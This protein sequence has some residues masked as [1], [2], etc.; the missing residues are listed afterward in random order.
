[1]EVHDLL[2]ILRQTAAGTSRKEIASR[3]G[4]AKSTVQR[5]LNRLKTAGITPEQAMEMSYSKLEDL[6]GCGKSVRNGFCLPDFEHAYCRHNIRGK[7][8]MSLKEL[9]QSY[10]VQ[11]PQ[12]AKTLGYKGYVRAYQRFCADLPASCRDIELINEWMFGDVAMI[13]YSGDT[14]TL[15]KTGAKQNTTAQIFVGVLPASGYI[16]CFAT[17]RQTRDDWLDAQVKMLEYF[18]GV[19]KHIYLDNTKALVIKADKYAPKICEEYLGF[20]DYYGTIAVAVRPGKPRDKA[21]AENAVRLVQTKILSELRGREFFE[22]EE[23]NKALLKELDKLNKRPLTTRSDGISRYDLVQEERQTLMPLPPLS[24]EISSEIK[25][26]KVQKSSIVRFNNCRYSVPHSYIGHKVRVIKSNR[27]QTIFV[28]DLKTGER[29]C[30]HYLSL[31][32]QQ[33]CICPEHLPASLRAVKMT[34]EQLIEAISQSGPCAKELCG[35]LL[36]QNHGEN[37]RKVLR[38]VNSCRTSVGNQLFEQCCATTLKR[39]VPS[40]LVLLDEVERVVS[41]KKRPKKAPA[42]DRSE[43][44]PESIRGAD[45]YAKLLKTTKD[46]DNDDQQ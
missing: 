43:L 21:M 46:S 2:E 7:N 32:K 45:Y 18:D 20:C 33:T 11:A 8:R 23:L 28:F 40:Y 15:K 12:G 36:K 5:N 37:A 25:I 42:C 16:F 38:G 34:Q 24:Y 17:P 27:N 6:L 31:K 13:D 39:A 19:P 26:L 30:E 22:I 1:M 44:G 35:L 4:V 3:L 14:V 10:R 9:W 41:G 29:I